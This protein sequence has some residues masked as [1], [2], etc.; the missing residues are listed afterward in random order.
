MCIK[1]GWFKFEKCMIRVDK[2]MLDTRLWHAKLW[3]AI[4][5]RQLQMVM[6]KSSA[7]HSQQSFACPRSLKRVSHFYIEIWVRKVEESCIP[8]TFTLHTTL[9]EYKSP[10]MDSPWIL[11]GTT[12][13]NYD[14]SRHTSNRAKHFSLVRGFCRERH[15]LK[16]SKVY[17]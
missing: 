4:Q 14:S 10:T 7:T 11:P 15:S 2:D 13:T 16:I 6:P 5:K 3:Q 9:S 17:S 12:H 8:L 1:K